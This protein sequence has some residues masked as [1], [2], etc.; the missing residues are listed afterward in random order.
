MKYCPRPPVFHFVASA[1]YAA[2]FLF[3]L[4]PLIA[5]GASGL[6]DACGSGG[7]TCGTGL[8]CVKGECLGGNGYITEDPSGCSPELTWQNN[9]CII[10]I[11]SHGENLG[12]G[13][14]TSDI[15]DSIRIFLNILLGFLGVIAV[16][17]IMYAGF[18]WMTAFGNEERVAKAKKTILWGVVGILVI[19]SSWTIASYILS[20]GEKGA[21]VIATPGGDDGGDG[22]IPPTGGVAEQFALDDVE[23]GR[24]DPDTNPP[25][26]KVYLCSAIQARFNHAIGAE[27]FEKSKDGLVIK[28]KPED[29][30]DDIDE[31]T[32]V[33]PET[34]A[35]YLWNRSG[36]YIIFEHPGDDKNLFEKDTQYA[37]V[38]PRTMT[39]TGN[40]PFPLANC[41]AIGCEVQQDRVI[42]RFTTGELSDSEKPDI[43]PSGTYPEIY[44][45]IDTSYPSRGVSARPTIV[46]VFNEPILVSSVIKEYNITNDKGEITEARDI[47]L[48]AVFEIASFNT[49]VDI[50]K[51]VNGNILLTGSDIAK[52]QNQNFVARFEDYGYGS[53]IVIQPGPEV[54]NFTTNGWY[55]IKIAGVSDLCGNVFD[56]ERHFHFQIS[57]AV[58]RLD[59]TPPDNLSKV[60]YQNIAVG[61]ISNISMYDVVKDSCSVGPENGANGFITE[62]ALIPI[63]GRALKVIDDLPSDP[64]ER[65]LITNYDQYC[66]KYYFE[67]RDAALNP[68]QLYKAEVK[69]RFPVDDKGTLLNSAWSFTTA[70]LTEKCVYPPILTNVSPLSGGKGQCIGIEGEHIDY[71]STDAVR[72]DTTVSKEIIELQKVNDDQSAVTCANISAY[73]DKNAALRWSDRNIL[74]KIQDGD[75]PALPPECPSPIGQN[76]ETFRIIE[77]IIDNANGL[78]FPSTSV[79]F[80]LTNGEVG[81]C[82]EEIKPDHDVFRGNKITLVGSDFGAYQKDKGSVVYFDNKPDT[83][84]SADTWKDKEIASIIPFPANTG[85][86]YVENATGARSNGKTLTLPELK[87]I[88]VTIR[89]KCEGNFNKSPNPFF[90]EQDVCLIGRDQNPITKLD[91]ARLPVFIEFETVDRSAM[92]FL[93]ANG[94]FFDA[95]NYELNDGKS[96]RNPDS[97]TSSSIVEKGHVGI[98][99]LFQNKADD[100]FLKFGTPY[101]LTMHDII[102]DKNV[103]PP[104]KFTVLGSPFKFATILQEKAEQNGCYTVES[105]ALGL[106]PNTIQYSAY[107]DASAVARNSSCQELSGVSFAWSVNPLETSD[108]TQLKDKA[109]NEIPPSEVIETPLAGSGDRIRIQSKNSSLISEAVA[110]ITTTS[111]D[112]N[113]TSGTNPLTVR[114]SAYCEEDDDCKKN[115]AVN[116]GDTVQCVSNQCSPYVKN[117]SPNSAGAS[118]W[119]TVQ[120][121]YFGEE[122]GING[123]VAFI[124]GETTNYGGLEISSDIEECSKDKTWNDTQIIVIVPS[125]LVNKPAQVDVMTAAERESNKFD[126]FTVTNTNTNH[127]MLCAMD[128][129][130][131]GVNDAVILYGQGFNLGEGTRFAAFKNTATSVIQQSTAMPINDNNANT[132]VPSDAEN[133]PHEVRYLVSDLQESNPLQFEVNDEGRAAVIK[134]FPE[135]N[136]AVCGTDVNCD[137][138]GDFLATGEVT[139]DQEVTCTNIEQCITVVENNQVVAGLGYDLKKDQQDK[140]TIGFKFNTDTGSARLQV[141]KTY[142][143]ALTTGTIRTKNNKSVRCGIVPEVG[144]TGEQCAW[145]F[146]ITNQI[147]PKK[148]IITPKADEDGVIILTPNHPSQDIDAQEKFT[149]EV[150]DADDENIT[151]LVPIV[152]TYEGHDALKEVSSIGPD[153]ILE[154]IENPENSGIYKLGIF[155]ITAKAGDVTSEPFPLKIVND[156]TLKIADY[157]PEQ[158]E[159][160]CRNAS[161]DVLFNKPIDP[162]TASAMKVTLLKQG[163][164]P[165]FALAKFDGGFFR[166]FVRK[167]RG[168]FAIFTTYGADDEFTQCEEIKLSFDNQSRPTRVTVAGADGGLLAPEKIYQL[169]VFGGENGVKAQ[170]GNFLWATSPDGCG[171]GLQAASGD[172][173]QYCFFTFTTKAIDEPMNGVCSVDRIGFAPGEL[174]LYNKEDQKTITAQAYSGTTLI[175]PS[176][177]YSWKFTNWRIEPDSGIMRLYKT[178]TQNI[179]DKTTEASQVDVKPVAYD[180]NIKTGEGLVLVDVIDQIIPSGTDFPSKA[181]VTPLLV[182]VRPCEGGGD[183][184]WKFFEDKFGNFEFSYCQK[185]E[186]SSNVLPR[187]RAEPI[188]VSLTSSRNVLGE[189]FFV[190]EPEVNDANFDSSSL[191]D[192]L[193]LRI[194]PAANYFISTDVKL[195]IE[196]WFS[197]N[198]ETLFE[199]KS[200]SRS[201]NPVD[202]YDALET[203]SA[204]YVHALNVDE[205]KNKIY[206]NVYVLAVTEG[207]SEK[208]KDIMRQLVANWKFNRNIS[209]LTKVIQLKNDY[210]RIRQLGLLGSELALYQSILG[211]APS[212]SDSRQSGI[213]MSAWDKEWR[214]DSA[215]A[216]VHL[217]AALEQGLETAITLPFDP[218]DH[219]MVLEDEAKR[220]EEK[221]LKATPTDPYDCIWGSESKAPMACLAK[222][223]QIDLQT[224][225]LGFDKGSDG[226]DTPDAVE[227]FT[228]YDDEAYGSKGEYYC[229]GDNPRAYQYVKEANGSFTLYGN[230]EYT[231]L[232]NAWCGGSDQYTCTGWTGGEASFCE[233]VGDDDT[234]QCGVRQVTQPA[235]ASDLPVD[236]QINCKA[237]KQE[238]CG[239]G[240]YWIDNACKPRDDNQKTEPF[241]IMFKHL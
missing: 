65:K 133:G 132:S 180:G 176:D 21:G 37:A 28:Q 157:H 76:G 115:C 187:L 135:P 67:P 154:A 218:L 226:V 105:V 119:V 7:G 170:D 11:T 134:V 201:H 236:S 84:F 74:T 3:L 102:D 193:L 20:L 207:A 42:W 108:G 9:R 190:Y 91:D 164:A 8:S 167:A 111:D 168:L 116:P 194:F 188:P 117:V 151:A 192:R 240:C 232:K 78:N 150:F 113:K 159:S 153:L 215:D 29:K 216:R 12:L 203:D 152:W 174:I 24:P 53:R 27:S 18:M 68:G 210:M 191:D 182:K 50:Q 46:I 173:G 4:T 175:D 25:N 146:I 208:T 137:K 214:A 49:G 14:T 103:S 51:I 123:K 130:S 26:E 199:E 66:R 75:T 181:P 48:E 35:S 85:D 70:A 165:C 94:A 62:G 186:Q 228:C 77:H 34:M 234:G 140:I 200:P 178:G 221:C 156:A 220:I 169:R 22:G 237:M 141:Q 15:R 198:E 40:P 147:I 90:D 196:H 79:D 158:G 89:D 213:A 2:V 229:R 241:N 139:F 56:G 72:T 222:T 118:E 155:K 144:T 41:A 45:D 57:G 61:V 223:D 63:T 161:V 122:P 127:P 106:E 160:I 129:K 87:D 55:Q 224:L 43:N 95:K 17:M 209:D 96:S 112:I 109:G 145:S 16:I 6:F 172:S 69:T 120:G 204:V 54:K 71:F 149:A 202:D 36:Q 104:S 23:T 177:D 124:Q 92:R 230:L 131:G 81:P 231:D 121:C 19:G 97:I 189:Y 197:D 142:S 13:D 185:P 10:D 206:S 184:F 73:I 212:L 80:T 227:S 100:L 82:L 162:K 163:D 30:G 38:Y 31:W 32:T 239:S 235:C 58:P 47:P 125:G 39:D 60:C 138:P 195:P 83:I 217:G 110:P 179:V 33:N 88:T 238:D 183:M 136:N 5:R 126:G 86:V 148:I 128:K 211:S 205:N 219:L 44:S 93:N 225:G 52:V 1:L 171:A 143:V 64:D 107:S 233:W 166:Y 101:T 114:N 99:L 59:V 98:S